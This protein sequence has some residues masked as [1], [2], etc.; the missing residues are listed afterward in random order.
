LRRLSM[1]KLM[2]DLSMGDAP[3]WRHNTLY[4]IL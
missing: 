3:V 4:Y 1:R 2:V